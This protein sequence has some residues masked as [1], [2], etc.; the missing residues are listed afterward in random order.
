MVALSSISHRETNTE[1]APAAK[2]IL[3]VL[4]EED[5]YPLSETPSFTSV[6]NDTTKVRKTTTI[7]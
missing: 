2:E 3:I 5:F 4:Q 1:Q 7:S 6:F